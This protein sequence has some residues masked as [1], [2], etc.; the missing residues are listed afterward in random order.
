MSQETSGCTSNVTEGTCREKFVTSSVLRLLA[1]HGRVIRTSPSFLV[2][3]W[4]QQGR[5]LQASTW[6]D[7]FSFHWLCRGGWKHTHCKPERQRLRAGLCNQQCFLFLFKAGEPNPCRPYTVK[8]R[9]SSGFL[10]LNF[11]KCSTQHSPMAVPVPGQA[12]LWRLAWLHNGPVS[13]AQ[14][15]LLEQCRLSWRVLPGHQPDWLTTA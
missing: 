2:L 15:K 3:P 6:R 14:C 5:E 4:I 9:I 13:L 8:S 10:F 1:S 12:I 11:H 7:S